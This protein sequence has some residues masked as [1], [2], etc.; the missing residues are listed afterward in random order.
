MI[1]GRRILF[2]IGIVAL[3]ANAASVQ[4]FAGTVRVALTA[5][6]SIEQLHDILGT[7]R[8][9]KTTCGQPAGERL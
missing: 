9:R 3:C 2:A 8:S 1:M 7:D 6:W 5:L 4:K